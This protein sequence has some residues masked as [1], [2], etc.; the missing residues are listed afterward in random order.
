MHIY[1]EKKYK[2]K[3]K[4]MATNTRKLAT[5]QDP[6]ALY[7]FDFSKDLKDHGFVIVLGKRGSG[8]TS[9]T[10]LLTQH[11]Q[12]A[13]L[14]QW[15]FFVGTEEV[16]KLYR[17]ISHPYYVRDPTKEAFEEILQLQRSKVELCQQFGFFFPPQWELHIVCDDCA[18]FGWFMRSKQVQEIASNGR[19]CHIHFYAVIQRFEQLEPTSRENPSTFIGLRTQGEQLISKFHKYYASSMDKDAFK[20]VFL[21]TTRSRK[22]LCI[23]CVESDKL[24]DHLAYTHCSLLHPDGFEAA[25]NQEEMDMFN[26]ARAKKNLAL[27]VYDPNNMLKR[28]GHQIHYDV[29][30]ENYR[31]PT[32][33][34]LMGS[35]TLL[36]FAF[37]NSMGTQMATSLPQPAVRRKRSICL[38]TKQ[39]DASSKADL[40]TKKEN[41][42][43]KQDDAPQKEQDSDD[44]QEEDINEVQD[45]QLFDVSSSNIQFC[46]KRP[47]KKPSVKK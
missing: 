15:V 19:N 9:L 22:A 26:E 2:T 21:E 41:E 45:P 27:K 5:P 29:A 44:D 47:R 7:E 38:S 32:L 18:A 11:V 36:K 34:N 31:Q 17:S 35:N 6:V 20:N 14:A 30:I 13:F 46:G 40:E 16:K 10:R 3:Q 25:A 37:V 42:D 33:A 24:E 1:K 23:N 8:K 39:K 28:L 43:S 4:I 12:N